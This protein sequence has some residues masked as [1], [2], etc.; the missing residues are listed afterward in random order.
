MD[1]FN[2]MAAQKALVK[3]NGSQNKTKGLH[4]GKEQEGG[5]GF[6]RVRQRCRDMGRK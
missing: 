2:S 3:L 5:G 6:V 1:I 4:V